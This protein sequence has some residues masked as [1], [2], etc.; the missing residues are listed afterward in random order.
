MKKVILKVSALSGTMLRK[1][2]GSIAVAAM[3]LLPS[4]CAI[5]NAAV[6][7]SGAPFYLAYDSD[8]PF[9]D[10]AQLA[11]LTSPCA[12]EIDGVTVNAKNMRAANTGGF[13]GTVT[14]ADVLPGTHAVKILNDSSGKP[15]K[16]DAMTY[17]F[18][19]GTIYDIIPGLGNVSIR[20]NTSEKVYQKIGENRRNNVF[21]QKK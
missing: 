4:G 13:K 21:K 12:L 3:L 20:L 9:L 2:A 10:Q 14:V 8:E 6:S 16:M 5:H 15:V 11:T 18:Q 1:A 7:G 19:A 17:T